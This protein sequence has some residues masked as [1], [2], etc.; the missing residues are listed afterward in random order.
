[1]NK[2]GFLVDPDELKASNTFLEGV[3]K[4]NNLYVSPSQRL[5]ILLDAVL[6]TIPYITKAL[7]DTAYM[8]QYEYKTP[9]AMEL[10]NEVRDSANEMDKIMVV[11]QNVSYFNC[12]MTRASQSLKSASMED[13]I[14]EIQA[15]KAI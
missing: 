2:G 12:C 10:L 1:M 8:L 9:K 3:A 7:G 11:C 13:L 15:R 4:N 5:K 14:K 6:D